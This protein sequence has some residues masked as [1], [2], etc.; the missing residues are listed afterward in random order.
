MTSNPVI[1]EI[2]RRETMSRAHVFLRVLILV[3]ASW[4]AGSG[5]GLGLVYL[6]L[7]AIAAI[8]IAQKGGE[9]YLT[10]DGNRVTG[11]ATRLRPRLTRPRA[12]HDPQAAGFDEL[13]N[14]HESL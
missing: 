2:K 13:E 11:W 3:L 9:R 1:F 8:L 5:G 7:P 10:D 6:G 4:I 12:P 14:H